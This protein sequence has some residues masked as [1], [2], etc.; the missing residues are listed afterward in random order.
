[1]YTLQTPRLAAIFMFLRIFMSAY[2]VAVDGDLENWIFR[3]SMRIMENAI[4]FTIPVDR[5]RFSDENAA[6]KAALQNLSDALLQSHQN[7]P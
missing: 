2:S 4:T 6:R 3:I 1:L 7:L 5:A